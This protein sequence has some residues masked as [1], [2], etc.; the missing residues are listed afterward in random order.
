M[1]QCRTPAVT[2]LSQLP[3]EH[4]DWV[5]LA[6]GSVQAA[7]R[8]GT[9]LGQAT[10]GVTFC[11]LSLFGPLQVLARHA[12]IFSSFKTPLPGLQC[13]IPETCSLLKL[14]LW[15]TRSSSWLLPPEVYV[16]VIEKLCTGTDWKMGYKRRIQHQ[17]SSAFLKPLQNWCIIVFTSETDHYFCF[18]SPFLTQ[19]FLFSVYPPRCSTVQ[20]VCQ[21]QGSLP[22]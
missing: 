13:R 18:L 14:S 11:S 3:E 22:K 9:A 17:N 2:E 16:C 10:R 12:V 20:A 7:H 21:V 15:E 5:P 6:Q 1:S 8:A 4:Q 19:I